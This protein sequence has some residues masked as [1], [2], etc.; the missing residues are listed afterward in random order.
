MGAE[1]DLVER[2]ERLWVSGPAHRLV[3]EKTAVYLTGELFLWSMIFQLCLVDEQACWGR[4]ADVGK[5]PT[6]RRWYT[7]IRSDRRTGDVV[8]GRSSMGELRQY[9][10]HADSSEICSAGDERGRWG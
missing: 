5:H 4:A 3:G 8:Q 9:Y 10:L 1:G 6:L 7:S 2:L